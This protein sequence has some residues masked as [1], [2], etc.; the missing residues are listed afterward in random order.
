MDS[1]C[2][3]CVSDAHLKRYIEKQGQL[4]DV[5]SICGGRQ[6]MAVEQS[7]EV[8]QLVRALV[9][10][11]FDEWDYNTHDG[12]RALEAV[13]WEDR[14]FFSDRFFDHEDPALD[15][16]SGVLSPGYYDYDKGISLY[17][18]YSNDLRNLPLTAIQLSH[19]RYERSIVQLAER[20]QY[21][22]LLQSVGQ[23]IDY[24]EKYIRHS[25]TDLVLYRA[26][27]GI[28]EEGYEENDFQ[29]RR[30]KYFR[31]HQDKEIGAAPIATASKGRMNREGFSFLYASE[32]P[33]TA[34]HEI[35]PA[36]GDQ[37]SV[38]AF[39]QLQPMVVADFTRVDLLDFFRNDAALDIFQELFHLN[40]LLS[41]A[42]GT[43]QDFRYL[44]TQL[45]AEELIRRGFDG[46]RFSSSLTNLGNY[47]IFSTEKLAW[48]PGYQ[49]VG[50]IE[51]F[52]LK[53]RFEPVMVA[54]RRYTKY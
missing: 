5:C 1:L 21:S 27:V 53:Y 43:N 7:Q 18:G 31:P 52:F 40:R 44:Y 35:R 6:V 25:P 30:K 14:Y 48:D 36:P 16:L 26:R 2:Q 47:A 19:S 12:G 51:Q 29:Y 17:S 15:F 46:I 24:C 10:F 41:H 39:N 37:V 45:L 50:F 23:T 20:R 38:G 34:V 4:I 32:D 3:Q 13:I 49:T 42:I 9:R 54:G 33:N 8:E 11:Y 22:E 28:A